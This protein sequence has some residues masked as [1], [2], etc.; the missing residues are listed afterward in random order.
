MITR[1]APPAKSLS[2]ETTLD[3][4]SADL[5]TLGDDIAK[6]ALAVADMLRRERRAAR[7][8]TLGVSFVDGERV[9]RRTK[10][11]APVVEPN[12]TNLCRLEGERLPQQLRLF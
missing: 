8:V 4:P 7:T 11:D 3:S 10:L 12:E 1:P 6:L 9:S 2:R 5:R